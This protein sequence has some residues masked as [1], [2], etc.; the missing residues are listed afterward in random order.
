MLKYAVKIP[1]D[2]VMLY[3]TEGDPKF[4]YRIKTFD[5]IEKAREHADIWGDAVVVEL[6]DDCEIE[7]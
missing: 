6:D 1:F 2:G 5:T 4:N 7:L 3:V